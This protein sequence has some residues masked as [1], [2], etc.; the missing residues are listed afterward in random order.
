MALRR[1]VI[2]GFPKDQFPEAGQG[3]LSTERATSA[4]RP[5]VNDL[6]AR[7][8]FLVLSNIDPT[9]HWADKHR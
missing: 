9:S 4:A 2:E 8:G 3:S 5:P 6:H 7:R 1:E